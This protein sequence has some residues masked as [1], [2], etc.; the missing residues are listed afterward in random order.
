MKKYVKLF[1]L[2]L[3]PISLLTLTGCLGSGSGIIG[4]KSEQGV[5]L[6]STPPGAS[7]QVDGV[8]MG[9][10]PATLPVDSFPARWRS[11][12][13]GADSVV[14]FTKV[15]CKPASLRVNDAMLIK[16]I[17]QTLVCDVQP[18]SADKDAVPRVSGVATSSEEQPGN[19]SDVLIE[20]LNTLLKLRQLGVI[21][22]AEYLTQRERV[23]DSI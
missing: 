21:D 7:I 19:R 8:D 4:I 20:R 5:S 6:R 2:F 9:M 17:H 15:G 14:R 13:Y 10:T 11:F 1:I 23:L 22:K 12:R 16:G 3:L 18:V